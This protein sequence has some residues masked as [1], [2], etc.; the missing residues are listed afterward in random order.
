[1]EKKHLTSLKVLCRLDSLEG[2][3]MQ[4]DR[5]NNCVVVEA[6]SNKYKLRFDDVKQRS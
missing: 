1:M 3:Y 6:L 4:V 5:A 2:V